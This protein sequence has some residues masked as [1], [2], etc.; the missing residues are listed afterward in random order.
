MQLNP[1]NW[2][3]RTAVIVANGPSFS[4]RDARAIGM[5]K[6]RVAV[7]AVSDAVYP[8]WFADACYASD[9]EWWAVHQ[10]LPGFAGWKVGLKYRPTATGP[11]RQPE[12]IDAVESSGV[13]GFDPDPG[14]VRNGNNSGYA[15]LHLTAHLGASRI[16]LVGFDM[17]GD[18]H[19]FGT[20]PKGLRQLP[21]ANYMQRWVA[22]FAPLAAALAEREITV[23]NASPDSALPYF[24]RASL[25]EELEG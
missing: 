13:E 16:I 22:M 1:G 23:L 7:M 24:R 21:P 11:W 25:T 14:R 6:G 12:G 3:G 18:A 8:C 17:K 2:T 20:H 10:N 19:W 15:A 9:A 5:A 4:A